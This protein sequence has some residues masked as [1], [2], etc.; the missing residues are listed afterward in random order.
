[1]VKIPLG[2]VFVLYIFRCSPAGSIHMIYFIFTAHVKFIMII[3]KSC[4]P[5][6]GR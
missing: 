2:F 5:N 1:M 6:S 4:Q 3:N